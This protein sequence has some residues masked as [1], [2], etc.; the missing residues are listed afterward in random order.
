[1]ETVT[2]LRILTTHVPDV[3]VDVILAYTVQNVWHNNV[4]RCGDV[5]PTARQWNAQFAMQIQPKRY[6]FHHPL[7]A[8]LP[9][10]NDE[11]ADITDKMWIWVKH[12]H[13]DQL[14]FVNESQ[15]DEVT[16]YCIEN[17]LFRARLDVK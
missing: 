11:Y 1:M 9:F 2:V 7:Y 8:P 13:Q 15:I 14:W 17:K 16:R 10:F 3:L 6:F 12:K 5:R 4:K